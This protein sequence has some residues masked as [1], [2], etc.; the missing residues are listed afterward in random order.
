[1]LPQ[2]LI[3]ALSVAGQF[4]GTLVIAA[5]FLTVIGIVVF[6]GP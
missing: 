4:I 2:S 5:V 3:G 6:V 1:V